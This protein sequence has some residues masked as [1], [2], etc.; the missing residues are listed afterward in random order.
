MAVLTVALVH[1]IVCTL[2]RE[3]ELGCILQLLSDVSGVR[4]VQIVSLEGARRCNPF[5][6][7]VSE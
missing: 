2:I 4:Q 1:P 5:V 6:A 7:K 3:R